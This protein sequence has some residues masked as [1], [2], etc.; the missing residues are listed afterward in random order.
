[1]TFGYSCLSVFVREEA[2]VTLPPQ[3]REV[4]HELPVVLPWP[5]SDAIPWLVLVGSRHEVGASLRSVGAFNGSVRFPCVNCS[6]FSTDGGTS[7]LPGVEPFMR[8]M[9]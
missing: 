6:R 2:S 4:G 9:G 8:V 1:M 3:S 5:G 7:M